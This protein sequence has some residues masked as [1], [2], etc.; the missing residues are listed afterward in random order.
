VDQALGIRPVIAERV[1]VYVPGALMDNGDCAP[2]IVRHYVSDGL[3]ETAA[4][5]AA[6]GRANPID[7]AE[8]FALLK[9]LKVPPP[10]EQALNLGGGD[11]H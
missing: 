2:M 3:A 8:E 6:R 10:V 11:I 7:E 1:S 5:R 4:R 9:P